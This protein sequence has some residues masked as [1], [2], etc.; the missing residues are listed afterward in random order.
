MTK[1]PTPAKRVK[2]AKLRGRAKA[3]LP[4]APE[5]AAEVLEYDRERE[6]AAEAR[7]SSK[8]ASR[9]VSYTEEESAAQAEGTGAAAEVAAAGAM[10][11]EEGRRLDSI[12]TVGIAALQRSN[13]VYFQMVTSMM[14]R[15]EKAETAQLKMMEAVRQNFLGRVEAEGDLVRAEADRDAAESADKNDDPITKMAGELLPML[16][17]QLMAAMASGGG[18]KK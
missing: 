15:M 10:V 8:S 14:G 5:E 12:L 2:I 9:K 3:G 13:E 17:P 16:L 1:T 7:G 6:L 18:P 11:K 4:L